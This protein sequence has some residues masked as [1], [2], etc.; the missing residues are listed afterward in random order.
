[1]EITGIFPYIPTPLRAHLLA[2]RP[3]VRDGILHPK[4]NT[5]EQDRSQNYRTFRL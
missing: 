5:G 4:S 2:F 3:A 1:M